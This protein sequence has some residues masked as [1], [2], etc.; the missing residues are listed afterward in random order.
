MDMFFA[1]EV[2]QLILFFTGYDE[3][4][5]F[6]VLSIFESANKYWY[7]YLN[8]KEF[9]D[10]YGKFYG[11]NLL[12]F[13]KAMTMLK[14]NKRLYVSIPNRLL[15]FTQKFPINK[16]KM[17][18]MNKHQKIIWHGST[19]T[20]KT[21]N[22]FSTSNINFWCSEIYDRQKDFSHMILFDTYELCIQL[23]YILY[24]NKIEMIK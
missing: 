5:S 3:N 9:N 14:S 1:R 10:Q 6:Y 13:K 18:E 22:L 24:N 17:F 15:D 20:S 21:L 7:D 12:C 11:Y 4:I 16:Q 19:R 23:C 8:S 2:I